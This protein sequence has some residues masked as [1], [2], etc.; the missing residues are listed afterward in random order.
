MTATPSTSKPTVE[1]ARKKTRTNEP[2]VYARV[3]LEKFAAIDA[4]E[5]KFS[6]GNTVAS[7]VRAMD[8]ENSI[9]V[10]KIINEAIYLGRLGVLHRAAAIQ[11]GPENVRY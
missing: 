10:M 3:A 11:S 5:D 8:E 9:I 6:F 2:N 7:E 4:E 1:Q